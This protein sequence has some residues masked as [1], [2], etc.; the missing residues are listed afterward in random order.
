MPNPWTGKGNPYTRTE[1]L[2]RLH[3]TLRQGK[4]I[5]A[6]GA[7][8]GISAK[9]LEKGGVDLIIIYNSGRFRM[10][11]HGSTAGLMAYGDAN[12]VAMEIGEYEV[13]PVVEEVPEVGFDPRRAGKGAVVPDHTE[14]VPVGDDSPEGTVV[15]VQRILQETERTPAPRPVAKRRGGNVETGSGRCDHD[16]YRTAQGGVADREAPV[17][18]GRWG[19]R[20]EGVEPEAFSEQRAGELPGQGRWVR[21]PGGADAEDV[22][23]F[24]GNQPVAGDLVAELERCVDRIPGFRLA[25]CRSARDLREQVGGDQGA[26]DREGIELQDGPVPWPACSGHGSVGPRQ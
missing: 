3:A 23:E 19:D 15:L 5:I 4:P 11:G 7:G 2:E 26:L 24:T 17:C 16:R 25:G 20:S 18:M 1:V 6:A 21:V 13:L 8:T 14:A 22:P 12:A 10:A 9:F